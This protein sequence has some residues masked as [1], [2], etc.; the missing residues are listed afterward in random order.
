[1]HIAENDQRQNKKGE[2]CLESKPA[3]ICAELQVREI[4]G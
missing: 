4:S 3:P 2:D 1:L